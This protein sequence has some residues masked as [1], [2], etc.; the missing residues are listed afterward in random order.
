MTGTLFKFAL[1]ASVITVSL[2]GIQDLANRSTG[3][4]SSIA[5][6]AGFVLFLW[7][8]FDGVV[9]LIY[10][11]AK[12]PRGK[13]LTH[14]QAAIIRNFWNVW[15]ITG[16]L[17]MTVYAVLFNRDDMVTALGI[18]GIF[19]LVVLLAYINNRNKLMGH[20]K[21]ELFQ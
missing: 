8:V 15:L 10:A 16:V 13:K 21:K 7:F 3:T 11:F 14:K 9:K 5:G 18:A 1:V 17:T 4:I 19:T 2:L 12:V 20:T 6:L